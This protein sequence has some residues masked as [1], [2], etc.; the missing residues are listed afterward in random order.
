MGHYGLAGK[1]TTATKDCLSLSCTTPSQSPVGCDQ[2]GEES[3][4]KIFQWKIFQWKMFIL[5]N[6]G[7]AD[8]RDIHFSC[9]LFTS[10]PTSPRG[11]CY[12]PLLLLKRNKTIGCVNLC[13]NLPT[14]LGYIIQFKSYDNLIKLHCLSSW[15]N[16]KLPEHQEQKYQQ[17]IAIIIRSVATTNTTK[18][19]LSRG[20]LNKVLKV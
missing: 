5:H 17:S 14:Q 1:S 19:K 4:V 8:T 20:K 13:V 3:W 6:K 7:L 16:T 12:R 9:F 10:G 2:D 18:C 11:L 15:S